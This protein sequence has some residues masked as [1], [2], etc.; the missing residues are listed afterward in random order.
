MSSALRFSF[1]ESGKGETILID[2]PNGKS[3]V[4]DCCNSSTGCRPEL[5]T[6]LANRDV[7]FV[8]LTHPHLDHGQGMHVL[9]DRC[10]VV[11]FWHSLPDVQ[12]F[13]YWISEGPRFR[14]PLASFAEE[15]RV[16]QAKFMIDIWTSV[17]TNNITALSY[18][19]SRKSVS[20]GDVLIHFLGPNRGVA[21][22]E[23]KRLRES[24][25]KDYRQPAELNNFSLILGFEFANKLVILGSDALRSGW[26][27]AF[28]EWHRSKLPK[29]SVL[30]VPHHG[31]SNAFDLRPSNQRPINPWDLCSKDAIAVLFAGDFQHPNARVHAELQRRTRLISL[32]DPA[33]TPATANPLGLQTFGARHVER[34][35][36]PHLCCRAIVE[37]GQDGSVTNSLVP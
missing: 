12:P 7:A 13:L 21:Q 35:L 34:R 17:L 32:F 31:A 3:G 30:K 22:E 37:I 9:L 15:R 5:A 25:T 23:L 6:E 29:A 11:E 20:I 10:R 28:E 18:D 4:V 24:V 26:K 19:A 2:F 16:S 1:L 36:R 14:S 27:Q 33:S 8:C